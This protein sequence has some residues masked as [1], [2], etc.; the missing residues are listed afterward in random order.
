MAL[1]P[2]VSSQSIWKFSPQTIPGLSL[3]FD[4]A[5]ANTMFTDTAG[6]TQATSGQTVKLWKDKSVNAYNATQSTTG[7]APTVSSSGLVFTNSA[8]TSLITSYSSSTAPETAFAVVT[9]SSTVVNPTNTAFTITSTSNGSANI[10]IG[11]RKNTSSVLTNNVVQFTGITQTS[12]GLSNGVNYYIISDTWTTGTTS[13]ITLGLTPTIAI[14]MSGIITTGTGL[15]NQSYFTITGASNGSSS[16]AIGSR[17]NTTNTLTGSIITFSTLSVTTVGLSNNVLYYVLSDDWVSPNTTSN[18]TLTITPYSSTPITMTN[19]T[20]TTSQCT[21]M[22]GYNILGSTVSSGRNLSIYGGKLILTGS[23]SSNPTTCMTSTIKFTTNRIAFEMLYVTNTLNANSFYMDGTVANSGSSNVAIGVI[24]GTSII[25]SQ[26]TSSPFGFDGTINEI[27]CYNSSLST[28]QRQQVEGYL[29]W[30][31]GLQSNLPVTHPYK[32]SFGIMP[33]ARTFSPN[34]ISGC[35][36]WLDGGDATTLTLSSSNVTQ[37]NDKSGNGFN[38]TQAT[39]TKQPTYNSSGGLNFT[40]A[41]NS[42]TSYLT[43]TYTGSSTETIF[44]AV[45][46]GVISNVYTFLMTTDS[47]MAGNPNITISSRSTTG[48]SLAGMYVMLGSLL[49]SNVYG[50]VSNTIYYILSDDGNATMQIASLSAP[51]TAILSTLNHSTYNNGGTPQIAGTLYDILSSP[52]LLTGRSLSILGTNTCFTGNNALSVFTP[53]QPPTGALLPSNTKFLLGTT[54]T[55]GTSTA[56]AYLNGSTQSGTAVANTVTPGYN[57]IIGGN[58]G[59]TTATNSS[60]FGGTIY[61]IIIYNT[62]LTASQRQQVEG[63]LAHKWGITSSLP[64]TAPIHPFKY[65]YPSTPTPFNPLV[66]TPSLWL[67][68]S[69]ASTI[70]LSGSNVTQW[71]DKSGNGYNAT[72]GAGTITYA[73]NSM[74]LTGTQVFFTTAPTLTTQSG[75]AVV[76]CTAGNPSGMDIISVKTTSTGGNTGAVIQQIVT[77]TPNNYQQLTSYGGTILAAGTTSVPTGT[78]ILN[79]YTFNSTSASIYLN[80]T[81]TASVTGSFTINASG[82]I[83]IGDFWANAINAE[84][85][86]GNI[87]EIIVYNTVLTTQQRQQVEGYL[88]NKWR[89]TL[90]T[91]HPFYKIIP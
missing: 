87:Y 64:A 82:T 6:T 54:Y 5:D 40:R 39:S 46:P 44:A 91:T 88:S 76:S 49:S 15:M 24:S 56:I 90:P 32:A 65:Y 8:K 42:T 48:V 50:F 34:D 81:Q 59:G 77:A 47:T 53:P 36:L 13:T 63:Y 12:F 84:A 86:K 83:S 18:I 28:Q 38:A 25:G 62:V 16:I 60:G 68:A 43:T 72:I 52:S 29:E 31:W 80:G 70:A 2:A 27:L 85:F 71:N 35:A 74:V 21:C 69:D 51:G 1:V 9:P 20:T 61:E 45:N 23:L 19:S 26:N 30:K 58:Y 73:S 10:V 57:T 55:S 3:W 22:F 33:F 78:K 4:G 79:N 11:S 17:T 67:D 75:F 14:L 41:S 7:N 89:I 66:L 37:W